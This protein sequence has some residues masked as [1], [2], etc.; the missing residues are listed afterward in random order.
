MN[1]TSV[2]GTNRI[3]PPGARETAPAKLLF[4]YGLGKPAET[5]DPDTLNHKEWEIFQQVPVAPDD[6]LRVIKNMPVDLACDIV[7]AALPGISNGIAQLG[8]AMFTAGEPSA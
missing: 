8:H 3:F 1:A 7:R 6:M 5:V 2:N 4:A